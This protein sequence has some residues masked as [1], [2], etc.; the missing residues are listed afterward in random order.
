[1]PARAVGALVLRLRF[2]TKGRRPHETARWPSPSAMARGL[3]ACGVKS[4]M[5][6]PLGHGAAVRYSA[7][8]ASASSVVR[9]SVRQSV[10]FRII[11]CR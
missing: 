7:N 4:A 8:V 3:V 6:A 1:M 5:A 11:G 2:F 9:I 10:H